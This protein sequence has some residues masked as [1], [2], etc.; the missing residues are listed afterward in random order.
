MECNKNPEN[1][2]NLFNEI[3]QYY[4]RVNNF[5]SFGTHYFIKI[6][7]LKSLEIKPH[8]LVL[9]TCCG[10]GDF[11]KIISKLYPSAKVIGLDFSVNMLRLAKLKNPKGVFIRADCTNLPFKDNNF[12]YITSAFGLRNI[13]N[14]EKAIAEIYRV[15]NYGGKFLQLDFGIHNIIGWV[16]DFAVPLIAKIPKINEKHY[17]YLISSKKEFPEPEELISEFERYGFVFVK[18][19]DY[20]FGAISVQIMQKI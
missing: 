5:I 7:A 12:D 8:A 9:D 20:L 13:K 19:T 6:S 2:K 18:R 4:D 11:T 3:A 10:T 1:I 15:L 16:F 14:R 17:N